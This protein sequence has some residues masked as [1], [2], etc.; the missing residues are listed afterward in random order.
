MAA[1]NRVGVADFCFDMGFSIKRMINL[2]AEAVSRIAQLGGLDGDASSNLLS[3]TGER[4]SDVRM[5]FRNETFVSR[6]LK[7]PK[8]RGCPVCLREDA[9]ASPAAPLEAMAMRGDW[10]LREVSICVRH[11]HPLVLLWERN[12]PTERFD[13]AARLD[14][15]LEQLLDG[16]F[17]RPQII[18]STYDLWLDKRLENGS[19]ASSL[20]QHSVYAATTFCRLLGTEL[21]R[22]PENADFDGPDRIRAAQSAGFDVATGGEAAINNALDELAAHASSHNDLPNKAFGDLYKALARP[23]LHEECFDA[24]RGILWERIVAIWPVAADEVILGYSLPERRLH[25]LQSAAKETGLGTFLLDQFLIEAGAYCKEDNRPAP[26]KTFDANKYASLLAEVPDLVGPIEM[27]K[28]MGATL[29]QL[30]R[31]AEDGVLVPRTEIATIKSPWRLEDGVSLINELNAKVIEISV[32]DCDWVLIQK[33][34]SRTKMSVGSIIQ[35]IREGALRIA[36]REGMQ[37]YKN[38]CV[39]KNE[40]DQLVADNS[41]GI[42]KKP[43][44]PDGV[45]STAS[46]FGRSIGMRENEAFI[47]LVRSGH[48][49]ASHAD[50]SKAGKK[51]YYVTEE[52]I[53]AFHRKYLTQNTMAIE[54]NGFWRT[55]I[56]RLQA[57]GVKPFA[58]AREEYGHLYLRADVEEFFRNP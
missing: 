20:E 57:A 41:G 55:L 47:R 35:L 18:P 39:N 1:M 48:T 19:D 37:G 23:Y 33:A 21:L 14:D 28:A 31:L 25:S 32:T 54:F 17:E 50:I 24:F 3:W 26:R 27:S 44:Y 8:M 45:V 22:L 40:V 6:A 10:Q 2:E 5:D 13:M 38:F 52:D 29:K 53:A 9:Q 42:E 49:P 30:K 34:K 12:I 36:L 7:N 43:Q 56:T 16:S 15:I 46:A 11:E 4:S 51:R 58:S